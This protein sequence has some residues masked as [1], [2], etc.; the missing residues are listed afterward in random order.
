MNIPVSDPFGAAGDKSMPTLALALDP[1]EA[2]K[3]FKRHLPRLSGKEGKLRLQGIRVIRHKPR[4]RCVVEYDVEVEQPNLPPHRVALIG[5]VRARRF[6]KESFRLL[7]EIW[8]AGFHHDS[9]DAISVPE[10]IGVIARFQM[11]FQRKA[12]GETAT[13]MLA[14]PAGVSLARR[15]GE[16]I[17]KLHRANVA[18]D[19]HHGMTDELRILNE[20]LA[21]AGQL[22]PEWD[23]R[24][25]KL[26]EACKCL[27]SGLSPSG[28]CGIHRDFYP[29][30][31][32]VHDGRL[33][34]ID[35]DLYCLGD[36]ALDI[37]NFIGH[38]T[39]Q[40]LRELGDASA[41]AEQEQALENS[42]VALAG[43]QCR[44]RIQ[45]YT[46]LTLARH[47]YLSTQFSERQKFTGDL[48][49]LCEQRL[50]L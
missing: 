22:K 8:N 25:Q 1:S 44:S 19:R 42:F 28:S 35:F 39:E 15:I 18:T 17:H 4:R 13:S 9:S 6:G 34:L 46:T 2:K 47:I 5:K 16:A 33:F 38:M 3:E 45:A 40:S 14:R 43:E 27:G 30:Q 24:L 37:G 31:V 32:L 49:A 23:G 12:P 7:E 21:N 26:S 20:C 36:P 50:G 48:L 11:W 10:P 41:M 29:A